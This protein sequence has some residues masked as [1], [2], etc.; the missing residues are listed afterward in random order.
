MKR[1]PLTRVVFGLLALGC[2]AQP[3][4]EGARQASERSTASPGFFADQASITAQGVDCHGYDQY[5]AALATF[6]VDCLGTIG[7]EAYRV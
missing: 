2:S 3:S 6:T 1:I 4:D 7:P 5:T